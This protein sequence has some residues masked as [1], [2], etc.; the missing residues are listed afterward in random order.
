MGREIRMVPPNW[1]HPKVTR[2]N[3]REGYQ[4]MVNESFE[5]AAKEWKD[6]FAK[7]EAGER[8]DYCKGAEYQT[9]EFWEWNGSPPDRQY[10]KPWKDEEAT[11]FQL[12]ET[13]SEGTPVSPP[14]ATK[15]ELVEYLVAHGDYWDQSRRED[16]K[17][18]RYCS[19]NC[20]PWPREVAE[21]F[22]HGSGWAPS[23]V[24][25]NGVISDGVRALYAEPRD[26]H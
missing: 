15:E 1:D 25:T 14:F 10:Y 18:G 16:V 12:W 5:D 26:E 3:G 17:A 19:M 22:V 7:W 2:S 13:V 6:E 9:M 4:P 20:D 21:R 24:M 23:L 11:W 8:P